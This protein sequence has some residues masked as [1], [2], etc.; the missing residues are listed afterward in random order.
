M[1][2]NHIK[3]LAT[4]CF[5]L[6]FIQ[7]A[8]AITKIDITRGAMEPVPIA[9]TNFTG[10]DIKEKMIGERI[11]EVI[12]K[13]LESSGLFRPIS[14]NAFIEN[15][16][17]GANLVPNFPAWR[18]IN[19]TALSVGSIEKTGGEITITYRL[20]DVF[21]ANQMIGK[22][23]TTTENNWRRISH[24]IADDIYKAMTGEGG[25][26]DTRIVY[27][28]E[29]GPATKRIKRLAIMD[30]DGE[31]HKFL[32]NGKYLVITPRFSPAAHQILYMSYA[33]K[34]PRVFL[35]DIESGR[36]KIV[37]DF[38]G[39][40]FA[41]R[42]S[43]DGAS[44]IM[45]IAYNGMTH[46]YNMDLKDMSKT[47]LTSG[48]SINTSPCYTPD[49]KYIL[50]NSDRG[51]KQQIYIMNAD[52]SNVSRIS[53]GNGR[54]ATPVVSPRGDL[55]AFTK[56]ADGSGLFSIG[57]MK[58]DGSGERILSRAYMAESPTWSP[59]GRV[60]MFN[61]QERGSN[62]RNLPSKIYSI[63]ITGSNEREIATPGDASDPAWSNL[64]Q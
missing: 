33:R 5:F 25:Y 17:N 47:K 24:I 23:L 16:Q 46:I 28:A 8:E 27:I 32:S 49:G 11:S 22:T 15:I 43:P 44:A 26:F 54:Y 61:K 7:S 57:V 55:V 13:D 31:N 45:S 39:M 12:S 1:I 38:P 6:F 29:G 37:G 50:F 3:S 48:N 2:I 63:D 14:H 30:Y 10:S 62:G 64:L 21:S 42:F 9:V 53:S 18:Q 19:A 35:R 59:N 56:F 36:E 52:G 41:P 60:L 51:G 58:L 34:T 20:W 40:S 4:L